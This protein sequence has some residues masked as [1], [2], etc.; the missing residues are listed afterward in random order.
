[1]D[2]SGMGVTLTACSVSGVVLDGTLT[3]LEVLTSTDPP[4]TRLTLSGTLSVSGL[5]SGTVDIQT[6]TITWADPRVCYAVTVLLNG[7]QPPFDVQ[8]ADQTCDQP[9]MCGNFVVTGGEECDDGNVADGDGCSSMCLYEFAACGAGAPQCVVGDGFDGGSLDSQWTVDFINAD[10]WSVNVANGDLVVSGIDANLPCNEGGNPDGWSFAGLTRAFASPVNDFRLVMAGSWDSGGSSAIQRIGVVVLGSNIICSV[11]D[12]RI[13]TDLAVPFCT[14]PGGS[15]GQLPGVSG[16]GSG[17]FV[18][19]SC[20]GQVNIFFNGSPVVSGTLARAATGVRIEFG[21]Y[22]IDD[23]NTPGNL[24]DCVPNGPFSTFGEIR[25]DSV[26]F[27]AP[28]P[29]SQPGSVCGF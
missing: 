14:M 8:S 26:F 29:A 24:T 15:F 23:L 6:A 18:I 19:E 2:S 28:P 5:F 22:K 4:F 1:V 21:Y 12:T 17:T 9:E 11:N 7:M 25:V 3:V 13:D 16:T 20:G 10:G 27:E